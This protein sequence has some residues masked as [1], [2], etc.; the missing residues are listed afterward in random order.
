MPPSSVIQE[1]PT[2]SVVSLEDWAVVEVSSGL[3]CVSLIPLKPL[4]KRF[5]PCLLGTSRR[6]SEEVPPMRLSPSGSALKS[7][8]LPGRR[9]N[10]YVDVIRSMKSSHKV[11][12]QIESEIGVIIAKVAVVEG[13]NS[14][15]S[16][17]SDLIPVRS[18]GNIQMSIPSSSSIL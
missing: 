5:F 15:T 4:V 8:M 10:R 9:L 3:I 14:R 12:H 6:I 13:S 17:G 16:H 11:E 7:K 1:D 18:M 2:W